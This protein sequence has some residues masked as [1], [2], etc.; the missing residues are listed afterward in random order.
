VALVLAG[1][2]IDFPLASPAVL[3][4]MTGLLA[5]SVKLGEKAGRRPAAA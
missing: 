5:V 4:V 1:A 2:A 3:L